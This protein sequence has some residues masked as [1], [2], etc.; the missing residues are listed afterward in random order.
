MLLAKD[1]RDR[2]RGGR[3]E[4]GMIEGDSEDKYPSLMELMCSVLGDRPASLPEGTPDEKADQEQMS[5]VTLYQWVVTEWGQGLNI[6][7]LSQSQRS[8]CDVCLC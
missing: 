3:A 6:H 7:F 2:E 5:Q 4:I 1:I 8:S